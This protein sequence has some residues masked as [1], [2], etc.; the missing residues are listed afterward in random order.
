M[1]RVND[2]VVYGLM[3]VYKITD[4]QKNGLASSD[5]SEGY[6]YVLRP[7]YKNNITIKLPV[8]KENTL[9][10]PVITREDVLALIA[11]MPEKE[12]VSIES[13]RERNNM[14]K[15][16]KTGNIEEQIKI[17]KSF[18]WKKKK[19]IAANKKLAKADEDIMNVVEKQLNEEFAIAL[20]ITPDEV[21][22]YIL[23]HISHNQE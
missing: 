23:E 15:T 16:A 10:R 19:K 18:Y 14:F 11:S 2:Y 5:E 12:I 17:V 4:I 22:P 1:F 21:H 20:N 8:R 3:G 9:L 6:Y 13:D 7:V